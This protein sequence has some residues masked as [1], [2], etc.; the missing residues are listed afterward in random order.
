MFEG[1]ARAPG[2]MGLRTSAQ[3]LI[4]VEIERTEFKVPFVREL[5]LVVAA[6]ALGS[7]V[8]GYYLVRFRTGQDIRLLGSGAAGSRNVARSAGLAASAITLAGDAAKGALA[9][10]AAVLLGLDTWAVLL[11]IVAVVA[12]HIWP[13]QLR[14]RGGRGLATAMGAVLVFDYM[15]VLIFYAAAATILSLSRRAT[16]SGMV[17][18]ALTPLVAFLIGRDQTEIVGLSLLAAII[19]FAHRE[20][21]QAM[22]KE[23]RRPSSEGA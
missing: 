22:I 1:H 17:A 9:A 2:K 8:T 7:I 19:L 5:V 21:I 11:V 13:P 23:A 15:I 18:V 14:F 16:L 12:G 3:P 4:R 6:Y 10:W 20:H